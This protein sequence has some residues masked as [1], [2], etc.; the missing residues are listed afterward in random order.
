MD[1]VAVDPVPAMDPGLMVQLPAGKPLNSTLPV[2]S[3]QVGCVI[4][5]TSGADGVAL[6]VNVYVEKAA[7]QGAPSGLSV[8]TVIVTVLPA[9]AATGV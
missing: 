2:A 8:V 3:R 7:A 4:V 5:P 9:S 1:R 6:T